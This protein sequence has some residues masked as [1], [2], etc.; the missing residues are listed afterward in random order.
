MTGSKKKNRSCT[1]A[2]AAVYPCTNSMDGL[3]YSTCMGGGA[4]GAAEMSHNL[5]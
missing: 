5:I 4:S 3:L 2:H 1:R